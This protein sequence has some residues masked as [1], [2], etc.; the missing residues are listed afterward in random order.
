MFDIELVFC[1][2]NPARSF[3]H[4]GEC[5]I[6]C[7][8]CTGIYL[9]ALLGVLSPFLSIKILSRNW[10]W[11]AISL[12]ALTMS[13]SLVDTN[14]YRFTVGALFGLTCFQGIGCRVSQWLKIRRMKKELIW[15]GLPPVIEKSSQKS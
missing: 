7:A 3:C 1:H 10:F 12:N 14:L 5:F 8:R 9:G 4:N 11:F 13:L 6:V 15:A 2:Q